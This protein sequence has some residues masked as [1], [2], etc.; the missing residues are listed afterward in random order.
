MAWLSSRRS[1]GGMITDMLNG[2]MTGALASVGIDDYRC[3]K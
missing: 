2:R 3:S 1:P